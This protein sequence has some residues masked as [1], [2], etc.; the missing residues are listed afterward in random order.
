[1]NTNRLEGP[2]RWCL[3]LIVLC[4]TAMLGGCYAYPA[5]Y[6]STSYYAAPAYPAYYPGTS[7]Y[8]APTSY[9]YSYGYYPYGYTSVNGIPT[10][11]D[12]WNDNARD[13]GSH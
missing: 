2:G 5:Y 1:M 6:P 3:P 13:G 11:Q 8:A 7:Y 4:A 9:A 12:Y 10:W